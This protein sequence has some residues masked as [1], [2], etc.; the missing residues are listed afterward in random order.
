MRSSQWST[1][2]FSIA[3]FAVTVVANA[4][5]LWRAFGGVVGSFWTFDLAL[6]MMKGQLPFSNGQL[7][8]S[9]PL[10]MGMP[11]VSG[12]LPVLRLSDVHCAELA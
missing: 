7:A 1:L 6:D 8:P 11:I 4:T 10:S 5:F 9:R 3:K 2:G 12:S